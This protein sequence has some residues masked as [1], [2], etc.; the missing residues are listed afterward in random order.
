MVPG[1]DRWKQVERLFYEVLELS[2]SARATFLDQACGDDHEL[3]KELESLLES[4]D[5]TLTFLQKSVREV[6]RRATGAPCLSGAIVGAYRL[7]ELLGEGGMGEVYLAARADDLYQQE[8]AIKVMRSAFQGRHAMLLRFSAERQILANLNHPNI[9]RLLDGGITAE[10]LPYLVM[11]YVDGINIDEYCRRSRM[12]WPARLQLFRSV[13]AAVEYAHRNLVIHRDIKPANILVAKDGIPKLLD[14][15][16]AKLLDP[17]WGDLRLTKT[18]DRVM[19]PEYASPEQV[20]GEAITTATDIYALGVVLYELLTE[21]QP[22]RADPRSPFELAQAICHEEPMPPSVAIHENS[23]DAK[24]GSRQKLDRDLDNVVLMAIRKEPARRYK[25]VDQLSEDIRRYLEGFPVIAREDSWRYRT[26]KFIRRHRVAAL[27]SATFVLSLILFGISMAIFAHRARME[28]ARAEQ[29]S[30]FLQSV[31]NASD[32]FHAKGATVTARDILDRGSA[33]IQQELKDQPKT[34]EEILE[35]MAEAYQHLGVYDRAELLLAQ[36]V[37]AAKRAEGEESPPVAKAL[38]LLADVQRQ[39]SK[40]QDAER[41]LREALRLQR[42]LQ[43]PDDVEL[44]HTQNNLAL[45]LQEQGR[46]NEAESLFRSAITISRKYPDQITETL[47]MMSNLGGLLTQRGNLGE[48]E[49]LLREVLDRRRRLLGPDHPQVARSMSRLAYL[50]RN[51]GA[52]EEAES[53][54]RESLA[55]NRRVLGEEHLDT[56][57]DMDVLAMILQDRGDWSG[58]ETLYDKA[59]EIGTRKVG[60]NTNLATWMSD[61]ASLREGQGQYATAEQLYR[62]GLA[63]TRKLHDPRSAAVARQQRKLAGLLA[64]RGKFDEAEHNLQDA[65]SIQRERFGSSHPEVAMSLAGLAELRRR[66]GQLSA[67]EDYY[68]QALDI[69]RT[70]LP[71]TH[72]QT[73]THLAG[74]GEIFLEA[75]DVKSAEPL[76]REALQIWQKRVGAGCWQAIATESQLGS[77]LLTHGH[78]DEAEA[79]L[80]PSYQALRERFGPRAEITRLAYQRL[81]E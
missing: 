6:A 49:A 12:P 45:V 57:I 52:Y 71:S 29:A 38:R 7:S 20:R 76:T 34:Q 63:M 77:I 43:S 13:C 68:H 81:A 59:I 16:V 44:S 11:E 60:E 2:S 67:A 72:P 50:L 4:C 48:A 70:A 69:D 33:R 65:I 10:G 53:L 80:A 8:V 28:Q 3:R 73:A 1:A 18:S 56:L 5:N 46:V 21:R 22:F 39:R 75:G 36:E 14:F 35:T 51:E 42:K 24:S 78:R 26:G 79:L 30:R 58:A 31:F 25:S 23:P 9:A 54:M 37:E 61:L 41:N 66:Q 19:T 32:P 62:R 47:V 74:L 55:L 17:A 64:K 27:I 15:G 40:Y